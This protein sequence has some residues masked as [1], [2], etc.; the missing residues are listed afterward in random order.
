SSLSR[1]SA[2]QEEIVVLERHREK[3][4]DPIGHSAIELETARH[5]ELVGAGADEIG[6][7]ALSRQGAERLGQQRL[8]GP[9]FAGPDAVSRLE[10]DAE[11]FD[12]GEVSDGE[13]AQ[14]DRVL[15]A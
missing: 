4:A 14:H 13:F 8:A 3:L 12:Q 7:S 6:G 1:E 11:V 5:S 10:L 9:G 15:R 2:N